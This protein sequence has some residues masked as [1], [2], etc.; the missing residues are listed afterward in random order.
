MQPSASD[1]TAVRS[2]APVSRADARV[3][4]L[5]S[6]PG[7]AS[8]DAG[9]YYAHPRNQFWTIL[10]ELFGFDPALPYAQRLEA[11]HRARI[12]VWDVL[13]TCIR[14]GSMDADIDH[15]S[16]VANDLAAFLAR[17]GSITDVFFNG[18]TAEA[19]FRRHVM[20]T[21]T[22]GTLRYHRLPST[23]PAH[24]GLKLEQKLD[25]W[26]AVERVLAGN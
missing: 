10:G 3:L 24:A 21:I 18:T 22:A 8:L 20:S 11:L 26:R 6:M 17:H 12:A 5:G 7:K 25:A 23:S 14:P 15:A 13:A 19:C 9:E 16:A 4:I 2:F 1:R